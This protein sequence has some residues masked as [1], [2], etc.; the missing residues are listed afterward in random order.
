MKDEASHA[1][2]KTA[3]AV[4]FTICLCHLLNDTIQAV[5]P[6]V[7]PIMKEE[8]GL[9]FAQVGLITLVYQLTAGFI[10]P[11]VGRFADKHPTPYALPAA[12]LFTIAGLFTVAFA[13]HYAVVLMGVCLLGLGTSIFHPEA[14]HVSQ[15]AAGQRKGLAQSIFQVGGNGGYALGPLLAAIIIRPGAGLGSIS[16]LA[17]LAV[18]AAFILLKVGAWYS[19]QLIFRARHP[20]AVEQATHGFSNRRVWCIVALLIVLMFSRNFFTSS[21]TSY[22][23]FFLM[24]K[25]DV[26]LQEAQYCLFIFLAAVALGTV[27]GGSLSDRLGRKRLIWGSILGAAPFTL[28]LPYAGLVSTIALAFCSGVII[29]SAFASIVV[30]ATELMPDKIGMVAGL[31]FG[32]S[33]GLGG[34][35]SAFFGW[36]AERTSIEFVFQ[37]STLLPFIGIIAVFLPDL[38]RKNS[39]G[40]KIEPQP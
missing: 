26:S 9:T 29:S 6:A 23:T 15:L 38:S 35:G 19:R 34:L 14:V 21:M 11:F 7:Y 36:L 24:G 16:W 20:K 27:L 31:F 18:L 3:F 8:F 4:L 5:I 40:Q 32:L 28:A 22:F 30:Y 25:F 37:V 39:T 33:F 17:I 1:A 13:G 12:M 2:P 10:Q